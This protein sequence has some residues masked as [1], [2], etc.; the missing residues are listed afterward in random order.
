VLVVVVVVVLVFHVKAP[1]VVVVLSVFVLPV[2]M[3]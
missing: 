3:T 2:V 1:S